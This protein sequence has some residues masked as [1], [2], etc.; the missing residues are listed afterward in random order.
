MDGIVDYLEAEQTN[1][2]GRSRS[3]G[4]E[5]GADLPGLGIDSQLVQ[6]LEGLLLEV[7][8]AGGVER[9]FNSVLD[10]NEVGSAQVN[11]W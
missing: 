6:V 2:F 1:D 3:S 4:E 7:L 8:V 5:G 9:C 10:L 11:A